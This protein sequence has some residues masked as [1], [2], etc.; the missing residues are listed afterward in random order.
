MSNR[1]LQ[2]LAVREEETMTP[3]I[4]V[5]EDSPTTR[6]ILEVC[7]CRAGY[8][9]ICFA[10]GVEAIR[11]LTRPLVQVPQLVILDIGLPTMDGYDVIRHIKAK[12]ACAQT[13]FVILSGRAGVLD[14]LKGRLSGANVYLTRPFKTQDIVAVVEAYLGVAPLPVP[15]AYERRG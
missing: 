1:I 2:I 6:K 8:E 14:K 11:W 13:I 4:M 15:S 5:I 12:P 10:D 3:L 9:A 7:L